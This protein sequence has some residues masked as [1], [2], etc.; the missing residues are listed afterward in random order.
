M[1]TYVLYFLAGMATTVLL[2]LVACF[3]YAIRISGGK[4]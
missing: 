1:A 3:V 2:E 4:K